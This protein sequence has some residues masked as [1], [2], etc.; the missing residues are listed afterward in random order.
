MKGNN[1]L[2]FPGSQV[3]GGGIDNGF[4]SQIGEVLLHE[5]GSIQN[6]LKNPD[7][8]N[9][10]D[11]QL[12]IE[13]SDMHEISS[14]FEDYFA[15]ILQDCNFGSVDHFS[16]ASYIATLIA[17]YLKQEVVDGDFIQKDNLLDE[18]LLDFGISETQEIIQEAN[19]NLLKA[20]FHKQ[21]SQQNL[22]AAIQGYNQAGSC[23]GRLLSDISAEIQLGGILE[24]YGFE[25]L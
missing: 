25:K 10:F 13:K 1:I 3:G 9:Y 24:K 18:D 20:L 15:G 2:A 8:A 23:M 17:N 6:L 5:T 7:E 4:Q 22:S 16:F 11:V 19:N 21:N 14:A 12:I